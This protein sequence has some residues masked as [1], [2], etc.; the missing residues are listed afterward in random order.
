MRRLSVLFF[1]IALVISG[2]TLALPVS[3]NLCEPA[4]PYS[5]MKPKT[6]G[7]QT[8]DQCRELIVDAPL[9]DLVSKKTLKKSFL[10]Q[11]STFDPADAFSL[12]SNPD[13][14]SIIYLDFDGQTWQSGSWWIGSYGITNGSTSAGYTLDNDPNT[15]TTLERNAIYEVW[16][17]VAEDFA[18]Y[19]VD[20]TTERPTGARETVFL[21]SGSHALILSDTSAQAGCGCGGVAYLDVYENGSTWNYPA[22]NFMKYG[23]YYAPPW[24]TAEI[25]S[26][27]VGHNLG[28][29]HDGTTTGI[30]YY[31]GHAMW[32][33]IMGAGRGRG[34]ATWSYGG[35]PNADTRWNQTA[36]DDDFAQMS[37][38]L[39]LFADDFG[40]TILNA[41][42]LTPT[43]LSNGISGVITTRTD[44]D[45]FELN[46]TAE[47][48]GSWTIDLIPSDVAPN[49]DPE[50][51]LLDTF[52]NVLEVSNPLVPNEYAGG[53]VASGL[54]AS[55]T[56]TLNEG[57]YYLQVDGVGQGSLAAGTGYD[58]YASRGNY[59]L[60]FGG[61]GTGED[62]ASVS[63]VSPQAG[64]V[65]TAVRISGGGFETVTGIRL[66]GAVVP[67]FSVVND[68]T[69]ILGVPSGAT[70]GALVLQTTNG[71]VTAV[72]NFNVNRRSARPG[73]SSFTPSQAGI[74]VEVLVSGSHVGAATD[75][76]LNNQSIEFDVRSDRQIAFTVSDSMS[77]GRLQVFTAGGNATSRQN[78]VTLVP[79]QVN[80]ISPLSGPIGSRVEISGINFS[81]GAT[82]TFFGGA[83]V[84]RPTI[85]SDKITVTVPSG[86][87]SGP[88]TVSN[89][90]GSSTSAENFT[91]T[92]AA[93]TIRSVSPSRVSIG[94][95]V[96]VNGTNFVDVSE[97][98]VNGLSASFTVVSTT[99]IQ[100]IVPVGASTGYVTVTNPGGTAQSRSQLR[101]R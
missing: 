70:S 17:N 56:Y 28:L 89:A 55:I 35:Y 16:R 2:F 61:D 96:T 19:D 49:L 36:G 23:S 100:F 99:R 38:Y 3:A 57:T 66:N 101:I 65:G 50:L 52:G 32:T 91:I 39:S 5:P 92:V 44:V 14:P 46:V 29:A 85:T 78:F 64:G 88:I 94:Q 43:D 10:A 26:H 41:Y 81:A 63:E 48:A 98:R 62:V 75:L 79:L 33:P 40:N 53:Y 1:S 67:T 47:T 83:V 9:L 12:H 11:P 30:E 20:V 60:D 54:D 4:K 31:G 45:V 15:F 82:V 72:S 25:I 6:H 58:D 71:N 59:R 42:D 74:G 84:S 77:S 93:P 13:A 68:T 51:T 87:Q 95:T 22:L 7:I 97:V 8:D 86:A 24:D 80:S 34:I 69:L 18:M 76:R 37:Q 27:E 21:S 73:I 90:L